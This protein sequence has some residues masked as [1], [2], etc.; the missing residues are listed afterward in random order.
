M[1]D[2]L[3]QSFLSVA[4]EGSFCKA[5]EKIYISQPNLSRNIAR[6]E[7]E[8]NVQLFDRSGKH[9][10]LTEA[11]RI[12]QNVFQKVEQCMADAKERV[13][14]LEALE[15][16][17][18]RIGYVNGWNIGSYIQPILKKLRLE[19]PGVKVSL[20]A[21]N[22][23]ELSARFQMG[24][25]DLIITLE[26]RAAKIYDAQTF[27]IDTA[28]EVILFS[29][30]LFRNKK[31]NWKPEDFRKETFF[32]LADDRED[33]QAEYIRTIGSKYGFVPEISQ[34]KQYGIDSDECGKWS[35]GD[36]LQFMGEKCVYTGISVLS[37]GTFRTDRGGMETTGGAVGT[38]Y[39]AGYDNRR[40]IYKLQNYR[41]KVMI[42]SIMG[43]GQWRKF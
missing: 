29:N 38:Q 32:V 23:Q 6:L 31:K 26:E 4:A 25:L 27:V 40:S 33:M 41:I 2:T 21:Y 22:L 5:A 3:V 1:N 19:Y 37:V 15:M 13:E 9:I 28:P 30:T 20:E 35:W 10:A 8:L 42:Q 16:G 24:Q 7:K 43:V 36:C 34:R 18:I 14:R 39:F 12:Y 11:G 17:M